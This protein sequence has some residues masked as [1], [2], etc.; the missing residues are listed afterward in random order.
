MRRYLAKSKDRVVKF[1]T[2]NW[3]RYREYSNYF[4]W[5]IHEAVF[6]LIGWPDDRGEDFID[7]YDDRFDFIALSST[8]RKKIGR[9]SVLV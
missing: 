2:D 1:S 4:F 5:E 7:K 6:M 8:I 9:D 3:D